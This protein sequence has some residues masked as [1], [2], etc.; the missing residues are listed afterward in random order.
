MRYNQ[1]LPSK[2]FIPK[3]VPHASENRYNFLSREEEEGWKE[4]EDGRSELKKRNP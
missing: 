2:G 4:A 3:N 1:Y